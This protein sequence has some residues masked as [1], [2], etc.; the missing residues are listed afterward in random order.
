MQTGK[1]KIMKTTLRCTGQFTLLISMLVFSAV[2]SAKELDRFYFKLNLGASTFPSYNVGTGNTIDSKNSVGDAWAL[3]AGLELG[4]FLS[5]ELRHNRFGKSSGRFTTAALSNETYQTDLK[6]N[7]LS[8][9][10]SVPLGDKTR[11]FIELGEHVWESSVT[12]SNA[13]NQSSDSSDFFYVFGF[14]YDVN[15]KIRTGFE[16]GRYNFDSEDLKLLTV[17]IGYRL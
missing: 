9:I 2:A 10:P 16:H 3:G 15:D 5:F 6:S 12:L 17:S 7:S 4:E 14:S 8:V 1:E 13:A 11:F